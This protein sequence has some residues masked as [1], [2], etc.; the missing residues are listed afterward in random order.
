M[1]PS[2]AAPPRGAGGASP[3]RTR[4]ASACEVVPMSGDAQEDRRAHGAQQAHLGARLL[5]VRGQLHARRRSC[6]RRRRTTTSAAGAKLTFT[7]FIAK[8]VVDALRAVP[9]RQRLDR[10]RQHRLQ[11]GHQPRHRGGARE[12]PDRA[13]D[14]QRRREE[15]ARPEPRHPRPRR[16]AR[17]RRSSI[18]KKCRAARSP[19]PTPGI[20]GAQFGLPI[21]NQPQVAILG[22][23]TIEKRA[24]RDR[25]RDRRSGRWA[26]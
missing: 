24:G 22:V 19:S 15:P 12:R 4:R 16:R 11:E 18:P 17:A 2:A 23:G 6:A 25:R 9:D 5:G 13:G 1:P 8:V 14:P 20:F 3:A 10:R 26:T 7:S 21:I